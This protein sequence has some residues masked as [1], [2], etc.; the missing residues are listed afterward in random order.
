MTIDL[1]ER[2][3]LPVRLVPAEEGWQLEFGDGVRHEKPAARRITDITAVLKNPAADT[4]KTLYW[5]Y[6]DVRLPEH[7]AQIFASGLR[8]DLTVFNPGVLCVG[9]KAQEGD[10][11]NKAA[12][13]YHPYTTTGKTFSEV[14]EVLHGRGLFLLQ[15]VDDIF[16]IPPKVTRFV[17]V[18]VQAGDVVVIPPNCAHPTIVLGDE[19]LVTANWVA[20]AFDSQYTPIKLMRGVAYYIVKRG[21][22]YAWER[23]PTYPEAPEPERVTASELDRWGVPTDEPSYRAFLRHPDAF[24]FLVRPT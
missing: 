6:R 7:E 2:A 15:F 5:M 21:D 22:S 4:P 11:W 18:E 14:Y 19:P 3:G 9:G 24:R 17:I 16:A 1:T 13:H 8:Y 23:N 20:R 10:E 12:G